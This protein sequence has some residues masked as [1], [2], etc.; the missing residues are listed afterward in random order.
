MIGRRGFLRR[1]FAS[2]VAI[3]SSKLGHT[4]KLGESKER[5]RLAQAGTQKGSQGRQKAKKHSETLV[6]KGNLS[7][8]ALARAYGVE[9]MSGNRFTPSK[10]LLH[11]IKVLLVRECE[12][13]NQVCKINPK[14]EL[15]VDPYRVLA[16]FSAESSFNPNASYKHDGKGLGQ[17]TEITIRDLAS[18]PQEPVKI[19]DVFDLGQNIS[20]TV[21]YLV[22][23][24]R[25]FLKPHERTTDRIVQIYHRGPNG[26]L[27]SENKAAIE[28]YAK[29]V[30]LLYQKL[31][32][33][34]ALEG[35][36]DA[37]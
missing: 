7:G 33:E 18:L 3:F 35:Y 23:I 29:R 14:G 31:K 19:T 10:E 34:K 6:Y 25:N 13:Y 37:G 32:S 8:E 15:L 20:G 1:A 12:K 30:E 21:R 9:F 28:A 36:L 24:N 16:I 4:E 26:V 27:F 5:I 17:L 2:G 11:D 22:R